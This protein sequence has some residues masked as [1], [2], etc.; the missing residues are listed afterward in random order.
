MPCNGSTGAPPSGRRTA[1]KRS[2]ST[3]RCHRGPVA[4]P[5]RR[6]GLVTW[7]QVAGA[8]GPRSYSRRALF[9][10]YGGHLCS[11]IAPRN[12]GSVANCYSLSTQHVYMRGGLS[13]DPLARRSA[14]RGCGR[15]GMA[16]WPDLARLA[17]LVTSFSHPGAEYILHGAS[18]VE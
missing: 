9:I 1:R 7:A 10:L 6:S 12:N 8:R 15:A 18:H 4:A 11:R 2:G 16:L 14:V 3:R 17:W 5:A 13:H